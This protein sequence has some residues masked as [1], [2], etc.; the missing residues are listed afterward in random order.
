MT[1]GNNPRAVRVDMGED[2][3]ISGLKPELNLNLRWASSW[4]SMDTSAWCSV[5]SARTADNGCNRNTSSGQQCVTSLSLKRS[6]EIEYL[7]NREEDHLPESSSST[8]PL[9]TAL[10]EI[11]QDV[12]ISSSN[13]MKW[14][15]SQSSICLLLSPWR[16]VVRT[17][18]RSL[19][20]VSELIDGVEV[21]NITKSGAV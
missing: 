12:A 6:F 16:T 17:F 21:V 18:L 10:M 9:L 15:H 2:G 14:E 8:L 3:V 4:K 1:G 20:A 11:G 13:R 7:G 19:I 5:S